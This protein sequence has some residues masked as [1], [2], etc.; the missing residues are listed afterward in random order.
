[1]YPYQLICE[2]KADEVFFSRLLR[3][4]H[5]DVEVRCPR[6]DDPNGGLGKTSIRRRLIGLQS[7]FE[8]VTRVILV[9]DSDDDPTKA[10]GDACTEFEEA[11]E[12]NPKKQYPIPKQAAVVALSNDGPSTAIVLIPDTEEKGCLD[13]PLP[14]FE[15]KYS[16][17]LL[18]CAQTFCDCIK[19]S[20]RGQAREAKVRLR[21]LIAASHHRNPGISLS[22]LL[23]EKNCPISLAHASFDSIRNTLTGL[24]P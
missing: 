9:V 23:E 8:I 19:A 10:F 15:E 7:K 13:S 18:K 6:K 11:N 14:S 24:F 16:E 5:K 17:D 21:S 2:G 4:G 22:L 20:T 3:A 1:V 12:A